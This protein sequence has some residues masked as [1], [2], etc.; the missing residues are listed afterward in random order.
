LPHLYIFF[1]LLFQKKLIFY[2][3]FIKIDLV[4]VHSYTGGHDRG[5]WYA[6]FGRLVEGIAL[7][8]IARW[9]DTLDRFVL[10]KNIFFAKRAGPSMSA[11]S[12]ARPKDI[13]ALPGG[14]FCVLVEY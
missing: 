5:A 10:Q 11:S 2:S 6:S 13:F 4:Y 7:T 14:I 12:F 1:N 3:F 8:A 9:N